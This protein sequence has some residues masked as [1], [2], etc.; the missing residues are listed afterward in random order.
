MNNDSVIATRYSSL[1]SVLL[2]AACVSVSSHVAAQPQA[3][4]GVYE[5][6]YG[7]LTLTGR[8][9]VKSLGEDRWNIINFVDILALEVSENATFIVTDQQVSSQR[10]EFV[11]PFRKS[12]S[13]ELD[14]DWP[15]LQAVEHVA[16]ETT[17]IKPAVFDTLSYQMQLQIDVCSD[18]EG[19]NDKQ[20]P[21]VDSGRLKTYQV[22]MI[23]AADVE[24]EMGMIETINLRQYRPGKQHEKQIVIWLAKNWQCVLVRMEFHEDDEI[25]SVQLTEGVVAGEAI[26]GDK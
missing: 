12:R 7:L 24:T 2:A 3:F 20:Y 10:Y 23:G 8:Q 13:V 15:N 4:S 22:D 26:T 9:Q 21:V 16:N 5:A 6:H 18:A 11:N 25:Y 19:F 1:V 17:K 14:F